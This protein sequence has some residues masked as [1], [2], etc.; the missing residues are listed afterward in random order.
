MIAGERRRH[1]WG[2][3]LP[4]GQRAADRDRGERD[5]RGED[6]A[7]LLG[8]HGAGSVREVG[9]LHPCHHPGQRDQEHGELPAVPPGRGPVAHH[10]EDAQRGHREADRRHHDIDPVGE[11]DHE[12][13]ERGPAA[14]DEDVEG[15]PF[16]DV[17]V[18]HERQA[19]QEHLP[20]VGEVDVR[21]VEDPGERPAHARA[22]RRHPRGH[23]GG[24]ERAGHRPAQDERAQRS[25]R[26][27]RIPGQVG[28][29]VAAPDHAEEPYGRRRVQ[30]GPG[31]LH[32][33][34]QRQGH[35]ER[36]AE[37]Q[38]EAPAQAT[39]QQEDEQRGGG[40]HACV[41]ADHP[42]HERSHRMKGDEQPGR[43]RQ[44]LSARRQLTDGQERAQRGH[45]GQQRGEQAH[46]GQL[47]EGAAGVGHRVAR[48]RERV[49]AR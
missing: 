41:V 30:G 38:A 33:G 34:Q 39:D 43:H 2:H 20:G 45:P 25:A 46:R 47:G 7:P 19:R 1:H 10:G 13:A 23:G 12:P 14:L 3:A 16:L 11:A 15:R 28:P 4:E 29:G 18:V 26:E 5:Q 22:A 37:R 42:G 35:P 6:V 40:V 44:P 49:V 27:R 24:L 9:A 31:R 36:Q 21:S 48:Q 8:G 32:R 17:E